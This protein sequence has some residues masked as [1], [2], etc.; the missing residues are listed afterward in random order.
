MC[1]GSKAGKK[2]DRSADLKRLRLEA[3]DVRSPVVQT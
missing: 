2:G 3:G 1:R